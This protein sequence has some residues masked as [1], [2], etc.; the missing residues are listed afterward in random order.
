M[1]RGR[2]YDE[3]RRESNVPMP[4]DAKTEL[5]LAFGIAADLGQPARVAGRR[6][7]RAIVAEVDPEMAAKAARNALDPDTRA[8]LEGGHVGWH[9]DAEPSFR[10]SAPDGSGAEPQE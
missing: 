7:W 10:P 9:S 2:S 8:R 5:G 1:R 6:D 4:L 3:K